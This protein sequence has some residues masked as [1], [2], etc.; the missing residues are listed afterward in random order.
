MLCPHVLW[1]QFDNTNSKPQ[2]NIH[3]SM[4]SSRLGNEHQD[5]NKFIK[6][7]GNYSPALLGATAEVSSCL[8]VE[9]G[10][11]K[12]PLHK[13]R[14]L[15]AWPFLFYFTCWFKGFECQ[16]LERARMT[17]TER[18]KAFDLLGRNDC[19]YFD[20]CEYIQLP[21]TFKCDVCVVNGDVLKYETCE[22]LWIMKWL[23]LGWLV[24]FNLYEM[25]YGLRQYHLIC[26]ACNEIW[27]FLLKGK[28]ILWR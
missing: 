24:P 27:K 19:K 11:R 9:D 3:F 4:G 20:D 17:L 1:K 14:P 26:I 18:E 25:L 6:A 28:Y 13:K 15:S 10:K 23:K 7:K 5:I 8:K 22:C 16:G 2:P 21:C 12:K